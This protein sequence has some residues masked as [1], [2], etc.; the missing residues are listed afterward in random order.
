MEQ[1]VKT[2]LE[3]KNISKTFFTETKVTTVIK[4]ISFQVKEGELLVLLGPGRCGKTV[5]LDII[6]GVVERTSGVI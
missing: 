6:C 5:L 3:V 4:D 2:K 1:C